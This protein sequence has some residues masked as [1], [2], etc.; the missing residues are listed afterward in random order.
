MLDLCVPFLLL[1]IQNIRLSLC[2][3][4]FSGFMRKNPNLY[5]QKS[6]IQIRS[7]QFKTKIEL[8]YSMG[9]LY[10]LKLLISYHAPQIVGLFTIDHWNM[11][12]SWIMTLFSQKT[13]LVQVM[14]IFNSY[15]KKNDKNFVIYLCSAL[16]LKR[17]KE[18]EYYLDY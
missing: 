14:I 17:K 2:Y 15:I 5:L 9:T 6:V 12:S 4:L 3:A 13:S 8:P 1:R 10:F 18:I 16:I 11:L 7:G